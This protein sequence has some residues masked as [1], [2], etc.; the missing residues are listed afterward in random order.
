MMNGKTLRAVLIAGAIVIAGGVY[1]LPKSERRENKPISKPEAAPGFS[2]E[3]FKADVLPSIPWELTSRIDSLEAILKTNGSADQSIYDSIAIQWDKAGVPG[4]AASYYKEKTKLT[5]SESDW[6]KAAYRYFDA[7]KAARDSMEQA[8]FVSEAI[9]SYK[10]VLELNPSNLNAKTDLGV[11]YAEGTAEPMTGIMMLREVV[12]ENPLH[13]NAQMNLGF[14]SMKSGQLDKA[15]ERFN[16]VLEI[17][18]S[19]IDMYIYLGEAYSRKGETDKAVANLKIFKNLSNDPEMIRN[20][21]AYIE[22]IRSGKN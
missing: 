5:N 21:D 15:I 3:K 16:K 17:N 11:L 20:V 2:P 4:I 19:R 1:F 13:E 7:F 10:K 22:S 18:S 14:L 12:T 8:Y 6:L 9:S